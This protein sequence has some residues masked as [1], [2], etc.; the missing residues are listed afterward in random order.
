MSKPIEGIRVAEPKTVHALHGG[1]ALCGLSGPPGKWPAGHVW[2]GLVPYGC[3]P[4]FSKEEAERGGGRVCP[5]CFLLSE[6][7]K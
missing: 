2:I 3:H 7:A 1:R 5:T 4:G 6:A